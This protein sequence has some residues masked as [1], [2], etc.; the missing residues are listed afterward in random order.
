[1]SA[2]RV[3]NE[4]L[5]AQC[6]KKKKEKKKETHLIVHFVFPLEISFIFTVDRKLP[7]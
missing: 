6:K 3:I 2:N 7:K 5:Q 1:M 4:K